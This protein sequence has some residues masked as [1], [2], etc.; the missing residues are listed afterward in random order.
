MLAFGI[1]ICAILLLSGAPMFMAFAVGGLIIITLHSGFSLFNMGIFFFDFI[2]NYTLLA[3]PLFILAGQLLAE[4]GMGKALVDLV[5]SF[6]GRVPGGIA[7]VAIITS[8]IMGSLAAQ[9]LAVLAAVGVVLFPAM[10]SAGYDKG[11]S[12]GSLLS[13]SQLGFLIP[14]SVTFIVY[15]FLTET[16]VPKLFIAGIIP[17]GL[18]AVL[19]CVV[20]IVIAKRKGFVSMSATNTWKERKDLFIKAIP[21]I[22]MPIIVLGGIYSGIFTPT[23]A[24]AVACIYCLLVGAFVY[25]KLNLRNIWGSAVEAT[26]L[27][28]MILIL[29]CGVMLLGRAFTVIGLPQL[30]GNWVVTVGLTP[31]TFLIMLCV[32]FVFLGMIMDAFAMIALL[33][34]V[35]PA[36]K[37]IGIDPLHLGVLWVIASFIGAM[38]PPAASS[39]YFASAMFKVP[40]IVTIRGVLPF[41]AVTVIFMFILIFFPQV[42]TWLPGTM[43]H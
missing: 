42:A 3:V 43:L 25:R 4:S 14:P 13:S 8:A 15:G 30:I 10:M 17:G 9:N 2:T 31:M 34:V 11:Y 26:R 19:L 5:G 41:L 12:V 23:E 40:T 6:I 1:A 22:I 28:S 16:S 36:V 39:L 35:I 21:S 37:L 27:T 32:G 24:G 20:A 29:F 33:P 38:T 7:V 18:L